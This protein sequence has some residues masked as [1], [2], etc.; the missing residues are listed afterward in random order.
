[1]QS[2]CEHAPYM[3]LRIVLDDQVMESGFHSLDEMTY[4]PRNILEAYH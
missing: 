1:M 2:A 3:G 4:I